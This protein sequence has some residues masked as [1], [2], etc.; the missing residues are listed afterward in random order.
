MAQ[1]KLAATDANTIAEIV[2]EG[3]VPHRFGFRGAVFAAKFCVAK[4]KRRW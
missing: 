1:L 4:K 3:A 2:H